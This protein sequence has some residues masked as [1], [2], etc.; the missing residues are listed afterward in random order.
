M[1]ACLIVP[2]HYTH[3][4][5]GSLFRGLRN[6]PDDLVYDLLCKVKIGEVSIKTLNCEAKKIKKM[7]ALK[8]C[9]ASMWGWNLGTRQWKSF[10]HSQAGKVW[11]SFS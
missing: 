3:T 6:L 1:H 7:I 2:T 5:R 11:R 4:H 10:P 9:S 8:R